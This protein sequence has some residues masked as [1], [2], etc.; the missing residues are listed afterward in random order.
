LLQILTT[1]LLIPTDFDTGNPTSKPSA[2]STP[3]LS[4]NNTT[5]PSS[6]LPNNNLAS[7]RRPIWT[8]PF[9]A[10]YFNVDTTTVLHRCRHALL[11][12]S[13]RIPFSSSSSSTSSP[14][15]FLDIL[16]GNPDLY[17]PFWIAT[18]VVV[19]LFLTGT[20]SQYLAR[21]DQAHFAYDFALL[22]GAAG[23]V[24]GYTAVVPAG[25]WA[26]LRW[27]RTPS[28]G[29]SGGGSGLELVECW[30][31]YGYGNAIWIVVALLSWSPLTAL[32][33]VLVGLGFALSGYFLVKNLYPV[34]SA[35]ERKTSQVLLIGVVVLHAGLA[36]AITILFFAHASP[37]RKGDAEA[38]GER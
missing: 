12:F 37:A 25:L 13:L 1:T 4:S 10:Q 9:Y 26:L 28:G 14:P 11:P 20:I 32:N 16:D 2:D 5:N 6:N 8:L 3:F 17:G 31:L 15:P 7:P 29:G 38:G 27:F 34:I 22:S 18:T 33:Y 30:A 35:T 23:L 21:S 24:Y 36:I 19:I